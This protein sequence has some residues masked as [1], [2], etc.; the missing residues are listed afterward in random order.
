MQSLEF[1]V[2]SRLHEVSGRISFLFVR[3]QNPSSRIP[4]GGSI[5][6]SVEHVLFYF[7]K[8][9][10]ATAQKTLKR[11]TPLPPL[12]LSPLLSHRRPPM[13]HSTAPY[14]LFKYLTNPATPFSTLTHPPQPPVVKTPANRNGNSIWFIHAPLTTCQSVI[15]FQSHQIKLDLRC[16]NPVAF[17][18]SNPLITNRTMMDSTDTIWMI[19]SQ[20]I[21]A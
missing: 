12:S 9:S 3:F 21:D 5:Y 2:I 17:D 6:L 16:W 7:M 11:S 20:L 15:V 14:P 18:G 4:S 1:S 10:T 8:A 13:P 19:S